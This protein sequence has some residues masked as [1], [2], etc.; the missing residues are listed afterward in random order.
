[1]SPGLSR[2]ADESANGLE[3]SREWRP[4]RPNMVVTG[5]P[6]VGK[7]TISREL[8]QELGMRHI[9]VGAFARER[10]LLADH[11]AL[12]EAFYMH[13]DAV[14]DEL[15]PLMANGGIILD[16]HSCDW[17]P[18]RWVQMVV[19]LRASTEA[20]YDRLEARRYSR[21]KL[22]EN[23]QAEIMQVVLDEAISSYPRV[24]VIE[25]RNDTE[26][27]MLTNINELKRVWRPILR[28]YQTPNGNTTDHIDAINGAVP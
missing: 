12:H 15:E 20:L 24:P 26:E 7:T 13:E 4:V 5:T 25:L 28:R 2:K 14:L 27:Q 22:D 6:G 10:N 19:C 11:D 9:E 18:E 16:H 21:Q 23:M 17:Y 8:A 1:M 3:E